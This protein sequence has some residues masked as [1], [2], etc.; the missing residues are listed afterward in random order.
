MAD[1]FKVPLLGEIPLISDAV[2]AGDSGLP[3]TISRPYSPASQAYRLV[4]GQVA[5]QISINQSQAPKKVGAGF[6]LAWKS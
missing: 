3:L 5:A 6:E 4:A 1:Q 2:A